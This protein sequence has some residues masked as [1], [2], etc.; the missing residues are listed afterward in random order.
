MP[1]DRDSLISACHA[2]ANDGKWNEAI[3]RL[4]RAL[5]DSPGDIL[6]A[7]TLATI[8]NK[9][10]DYQRARELFSRIKAAVPDMTVAGLGLAESLIG[11]AEIEPA[12]EI[13]KTEALAAPQI[14]DC[15]A[16]LGSLQLKNNNPDLAARQF[17]R[18]F[19][20]APGSIRSQINLAEILSRTMAYDEAEPLYRAALAQAPDNPEI[21]MN[22]GIHLIAKGQFKEGWRYF[23]ARL[24]PRYE[25]APV[26]SISLPR[27]KG[28]RED[29]SKRHLLVMSEQGIGDEIRL[30]GAL[31]LLRDHFEAITVEC[32]PRLTGLIERSLEAAKAHGFVRRKQ[33]NQGHYSYG[34]LPASGGPDCY[35]ELGSIPH[36]LGLELRAPLNPGGYLRPR[37][38][39]RAHLASRLAALAAG[40]KKVGIVWASGRSNFDRSNNYPALHFWKQ[41]LDLPDCCFIA[42]QYGEALAQTAQFEREAGISLNKLEDLDFRSDIESLAAVLAELDLVIGVGTATTGLAGAVGTPTIELASSLGW[43]PILNEVDGYLGAVRYVAQQTLGDWNGPM[44]RARELALEYLKNS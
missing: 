25:T 19:W 13:L 44:T 22:Y 16:H 28:P 37:S 5:N 3:A 43:V 29:S 12:V 34:W 39:L 42:L 31:P 9:S 40:R 32:D 26:R 14:A 17:R 7:F 21:R 2:L 41:T 23:E 11:L 18:A 33:G 10:G 36:V 8:L 15:Y 20:L 24:D 4:F 38:D 27:W 6:I 35:L 30:G 1:E